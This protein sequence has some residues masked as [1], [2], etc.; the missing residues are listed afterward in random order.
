MQSS[1]ELIYHAL[2]YIDAESTIYRHTRTHISTGT[3]KEGAAPRQ[4]A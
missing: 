4:S 3:D 2:R 1:A